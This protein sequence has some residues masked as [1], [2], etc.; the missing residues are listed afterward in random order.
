MD[1]KQMVVGT[2]LLLPCYV[3]GC[4]LFGGDVHYVFRVK[5]SNSDGVWNE[6]GC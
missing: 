3:D 6:G 4:S 2:T 1:V 5:A